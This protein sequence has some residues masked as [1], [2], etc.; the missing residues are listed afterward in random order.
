MKIAAI[1]VN[2]GATFGVTVTA[3]ATGCRLD[4][5]VDDVPGASAHLLPA[6][7]TVPDAT[8]DPDLA[9]QV[10]LND[11]LDDDVLAMAGGVV[12]RRDGVSAGVP[13]HYWWF[14]P[15]T[16]APS[17]L[18]VF[19]A[20]TGAGLVPIDHPGLVDAL[21]GDPAYS[22]LHTIVQVTVTSK[23]AG[24]LITTPAA[25]ADAIELGLVETPVPSGNFV[26]SPIVLPGTTL[27]VGGAAPVPPVAIYGDGHVVGAFRFGGVLGVQPGAA[28][29]PTSQVSYVREALGPGYD[30]ERPIFQ[31]T[32]P[33]APPGMSANYT[34]LSVVINVDLA[35]GVPASQIVR[36]SDLFIRSPEGE[37]T[38]TTRAVS[39]FQVTDMSLVLQLQFAD[40]QP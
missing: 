19:Y 31:A 12:A 21:P 6:G 7:G 14:G 15:A 25:L 9:N 24:E 32:I 34:P 22:P 40:G 11:G 39:R 38:G 29:Q 23:Y 33:T 18:Y 10:A 26:A 4:P 16:L 37:I 17:P 8:D 1:I 20:D 30:T 36:D 5:L 27:D 13:V 35:P 3:M 2:F 28:F